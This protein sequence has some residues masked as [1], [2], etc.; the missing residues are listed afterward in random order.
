MQPGNRAGSEGLTA[1]RLARLFHGPLALS[2]SL[3]GSSL[4]RTSALPFPEG[5]EREPIVD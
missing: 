1:F 4:T 3:G 2:L 5:I